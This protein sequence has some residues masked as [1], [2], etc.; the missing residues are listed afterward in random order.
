MQDLDR[1]PSSGPG[2]MRARVSSAVSSS[3]V[4]ATPR[5]RAGLGGQQVDGI[6]GAVEV[7]HD[8]GDMR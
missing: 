1:Y 3:M 7:G 6:A 2:S 4:S 8:G 5:S